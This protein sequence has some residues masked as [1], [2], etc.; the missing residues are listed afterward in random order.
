MYEAI[1]NEI[2][3]LA[4]WVIYQCVGDNEAGY[5]GFATKDISKL[6]NFVTEPDM[7]PSGT[8]REWA[9]RKNPSSELSTAAIP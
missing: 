6:T 3:G 2:R 8:Y 7:N 9:M 4:A 5:G 1:P